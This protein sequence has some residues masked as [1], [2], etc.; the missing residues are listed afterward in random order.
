MD[1]QSILLSIGLIF[2][3]FLVAEFQNAYLGKQEK[4]TKVIFGFLGI[5]FTQKDFQR[6]FFSMSLGIALMFLLPYFR[7]LTGV[8]FDGRIAALV[9][10]YSPST[11]M[12]LIKKRL[13]KNNSN[14]K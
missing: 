2:L 8:N 6:L 11:V 1:L 5:T 7:E 12:L 14:K 9:T 10:G 4:E 13:K 3:G